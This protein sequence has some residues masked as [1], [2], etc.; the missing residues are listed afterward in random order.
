MPPGGGGLYFFYTN[1][2]VQDQEEANFRMERN[3]DGICR[4]ISDMD[5]GGVN[6]NTMA[7]CGNIERVQEGN[8]LSREVVKTCVTS[9]CSLII[10]SMYFYAAHNKH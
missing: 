6:D 9:H 4:A 10:P 3:G 7:S 2:F 1:F 8:Q 5:E